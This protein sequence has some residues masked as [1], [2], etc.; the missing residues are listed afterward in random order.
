MICK[1][2]AFEIIGLWANLLISH[3][4]QMSGF[5]LEVIKALY[6][7][8]NLGSPTNRDRI[9]QL[10]TSSTVY[11]ENVRVPALVASGTRHCA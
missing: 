10:Y 7:R 4:N 1:H 11:I 9:L 6:G 2:I 5:W 3:I 8:R